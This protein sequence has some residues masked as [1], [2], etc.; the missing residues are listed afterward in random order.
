MNKT[1]ELP[2]QINTL[3]EKHEVH[4]KVLA[5]ELAILV[6]QRE[7]TVLKQGHQITKDVL[8]G[9]GK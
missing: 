8:G 3:L 5:Y 2:N 1:E 6:L 9:I 4:N 7:K